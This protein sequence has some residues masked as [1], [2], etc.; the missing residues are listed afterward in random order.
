VLQKSALLSATVQALQRTQ[1]RF[2]LTSGHRHAMAGLLILGLVSIPGPGAMANDASLYNARIKWTEDNGQTVTLDQWKGKPVFITMAYSSCRKIC[3]VTLKKLE[4]FQALLDE[5]K[6]TAEIVVVS[7]DPKNDTPQVW[8]EYRHQHGLN[9]K[10]WH[11]LTGTE[12]DTQRFARLLGLG[13]FWSY[14][15]H[16]LH[17]F[18]ISIL[19]PYG[20]IERQVEWQD[21][22]KK[23]TL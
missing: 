8:S 13:E 9:R 10:N 1:G 12:R 17:D 4:E 6:Q 20:A 23:L 15:G 3:S 16:I 21:L 14:D 2:A 19:D 7:Y 18:R 22:S 11:F 5:K